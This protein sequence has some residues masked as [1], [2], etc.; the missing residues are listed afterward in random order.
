M[1]KPGTGCKDA[2]K[3]F[4]MK[5]A[6]A[7]NQEFRA[8]P[9]VVGDQLIIRHGNSGLDFLGSKHVDDIKIGCP[10]KLKPSFITA[11]EKVSGKGEF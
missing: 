7:T 10:D 5:L 6:Q 2:P 11:L 4:A 1:T 8:R 9:S 3:C